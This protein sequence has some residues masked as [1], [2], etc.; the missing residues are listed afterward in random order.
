MGESEH[1][2]P[3][4]SW[5]SDRYKVLQE[6]G[7]GGSGIVYRVLDTR[8]NVELA[9]KVLR[10]DKTDARSTRL[11]R[12]EYRMLCQLTHPRIVSVYEYGVGSTGAYYTME[13]LD[14]LDVREAAP[15]PMAEVCRLLRDVASALAMLH[16]RRL[17]HRDVS[18]RNVRCTASGCAKLIDFGALTPIGT[19]AE[20]IGTPPFIPPEAVHG[21]ALEPRSDLYSLGALAY[22]MLTARHAYPA[23]NLPTLQRLWAAEPPPRVSE[24]VESVPLALDRLVMSM[25]SQD[26]QA[27]PA[28]AAEVMDRLGAI[29]DL[30]PAEDLGVAAAYLAKPA[31]VGRERERD[32][33]RDY[34]KREHDARRRGTLLI[35]GAE[36]VGKTRML[37]EF[38]I[39]AKLADWVAIGSRKSARAEP[40]ALLRD[41][42][43][44]L[45]AYLPDLAQQVDADDRAS[46]PRVRHHHAC[47]ANTV[48]RRAAAPPARCARALL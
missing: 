48:V 6:L 23:S 2:N 15:L 4:E 37:E 17:L 5:V 12:A 35:E 45:F 29:A 7:V 20:V 11:F 43:E 30:P 18:Y 41:L 39:E 47:G 1:S 13:L 33:I 31:L 46:I 3:T 16:A 36:G 27:R 26:L 34:L 21:K 25:L 32:Q 44:Q 19:T 9:L 24:L 22:W 28:S 8:E 10:A 40:Y 14:G 42:I 38:M